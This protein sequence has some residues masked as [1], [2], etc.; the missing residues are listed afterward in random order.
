MHVLP[1]ALH[2]LLGVC[3]AAI[4]ACTMLSGCAAT[5]VAIREQFGVAKR[6][7]LVDRVEETRDSQNSAKTQFDSALQEFLA[8]TGQ[9][10]KGGDLEAKYAK[11]SKEYQRCESRAKAVSERIGSVEYVAAKLF[12]E[13]EAELAQYSSANMRAQSQKM[14]DDTKSRYA[15]LIASMKSAESKMKPVLAAFKDQELFLKHN[16]NAQAI[17]SLQGT[18]TEI[19]SDVTRLIQEMESSIAEANAFIQQM[20]TK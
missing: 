19:Q 11:F 15:Q 16:L 2:R 18:A 14:L 12:K 10:G 7:Q 3:A 9:T 6:E 5:G 20:G 4:V 17:A 8:V 13:W 1:F